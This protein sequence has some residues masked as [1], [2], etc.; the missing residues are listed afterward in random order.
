MFKRICSLLCVLSL[1]VGLFSFLGVSVQAE[2]ALEAEPWKNKVD[3]S[4]IDSSKKLAF[5]FDDGPIGTY[6]SAPSQRILDVMEEYGMHCTFFYWGNKINNSNIGEIERAYSLGCEIGNHSYTHPYLTNMNQS[7]IQNEIQQTNDLLSPVSGNSA[8]LIRP[9]YGSVNNTVSSSVN[10]PL[11]NWSLDSA[12]WNNGNYNSVLSKLRNVKDG[13]IV[14]MHENYEFTAQAVETVVP[15]LIEKGFVIVSVSELMMMKGIELK[16][17]TVYSNQAVGKPN[18]YKPAPS[19]LVVKQ[20]DAIGEVTLES[21]EA[22]KAARAAYDALT[23]EEKALVNNIDLLTEAI[24]RLAQLKAEATMV[25]AVESKI[26]SIGEVMLEKEAFIKEARKLFDDLPMSLKGQVKNYDVLVKAEEALAE[27]KDQNF[28]FTDVSGWYEEA[29]RYNYR[30]GLMQGTSDTTFSPD[31]I[32][33]RAQLVTILH[34]L[35]GEPEVPIECTFTD[36]P[37][38]QWYSKAIKWAAAMGIVNGVGNNKFDPDGKITREQ[39]ATILHR[40]SGLPNAEGSLDTFPDKDSVS[41][42]AIDGMAWA[43]GEGLINGVSVN[44]ETKLAP[45]DNATRAQIAAIMMRYQQG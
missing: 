1:L 22:I 43:V 44:G 29:V 26:D 34:R 39:I 37:E 32:V 5:T 9:P 13:D 36:V 25:L 10:G 21:E 14:L 15:E 2:D 8:T 12:D 17:G 42:F 19:E 20:I 38:G 23:E 41:S 18:V 45:L 7:Q 35:E 28:P 40:Y 30:N 4:W 3:V 24:A 31:G 27:L 11:I 16:A 33:T 6:S